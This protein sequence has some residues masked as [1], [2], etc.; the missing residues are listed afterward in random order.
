MDRTYF[1]DCRQGADAVADA[2]LTR[3]ELQRSLYASASLPTP[4]RSH[5]AVPSS[6][7]ASSHAVSIPTPGAEGR[8]RRDLL[9]LKRLS[10]AAGYLTND[11]QERLQHFETAGRYSVRAANLNSPDLVR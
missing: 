1:N 11:S 9:R 3:C 5:V 8:F 6:E 7:W 4:T 2:T 10:T